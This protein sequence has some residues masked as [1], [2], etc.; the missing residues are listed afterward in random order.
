MVK[1]KKMS[2]F[3]KNLQVLVIKKEAVSMN[4]LTINYLM[5][6]T[7]TSKEW[8]HQGQVNYFK[9]SV[10]RPSKNKISGKLQAIQ[11]GSILK[12]DNK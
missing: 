11:W 7:S 12:I 3:I 2:I 6:L 9:L 10:S 4:R 5:K 8:N 1:L